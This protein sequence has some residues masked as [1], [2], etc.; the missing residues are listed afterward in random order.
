MTSRTLL[1][2]FSEICLGSSIQLKISCSEN[3]LQDFWLKYLKKQK[4]ACK[5]KHLL[6]LILF[7]IRLLIQRNI[8]GFEGQGWVMKVDYNINAFL[9]KKYVC[10]MQYMISCHKWLKVSR[11]CMHNY[12]PLSSWRLDRNIHLSKIMSWRYYTSRELH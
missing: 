5:L 8:K 11:S 7:F 3:P 9:K 4:I 12:L 2:T 6:L 1:K 10:I